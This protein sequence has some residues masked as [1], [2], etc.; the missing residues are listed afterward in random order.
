MGKGMG[1]YGKEDNEG[2]NGLLTFETVRPHDEAADEAPSSTDNNENRHE[3]HDPGVVKEE[4]GIFETRETETF[5]QDNEEKIENDKDKK[6][7]SHESM[8][9]WS[10]VLYP[11]IFKLAELA[12]HIDKCIGYPFD[13]TLVSS[14]LLAQEHV[15]QQL[16]NAKR[17]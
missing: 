1:E 14:L 15:L 5:S 10:P 16:L 3:I 11:E 4:A 12:E 7:P 13:P 2:F 8:T 6:S 9:E 17:E